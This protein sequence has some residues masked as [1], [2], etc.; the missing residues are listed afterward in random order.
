[1]KF[2]TIHTDSTFYF[3]G[4]GASI[5]ECGFKLFVGKE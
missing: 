3:G 2:N 5:E 1:M 4:S